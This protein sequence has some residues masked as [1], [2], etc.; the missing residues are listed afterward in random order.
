MQTM[1][2]AEAKAKNLPLCSRCPGSTTPKAP[3]K[4]KK[5]EATQAGAAAQA[6]E[7][8]V[9]Y[10]P[11]KKRCHLS[12]CKRRSE[13]MSTMTLTEA[14][15]QGLPLCSKCPGSTTSGEPKKNQGGDSDTE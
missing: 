6:G 12:D 3:K 4:P 9:Y 8:M 15:A 2:W 11:G 7:I 10:V 1:T 14:K 5:E 13:G